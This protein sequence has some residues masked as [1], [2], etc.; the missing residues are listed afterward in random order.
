MELRDG[1]NTRLVWPEIELHVGTDPNGRNV[2]VLTGPEPD[3]AW[4][5]FSRAVGDLA[6]ELGVSKAVFFGAYPFATPHTR[7]SR[8]SSSSP[9][10]ELVTS[11]ALLRNSVDVPAGIAAALEHALHAKGIPVLGMWA[12]V[13]H[14]LGNMTY[15]AASVAL[16]EGLTQ[17]TGVAVDRRALDRETALQ[18]ARI[19]QLIGGNDEH[20]AMVRQLEELYDSSEQ[21]TLALGDGLGPSLT[22]G[23][24][25][26]A[27]ELGEEFE[28]FL[29]EQG[30]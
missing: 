9:S 13:P 6:A 23:S 8:L 2:L 4:R 11:L 17:W 27:D 22:S 30:E 18:R 12:Q 20:L 26:T 25:P 28:R 24:L 29:R 16:V 1:V 10:A 14:Y 19:D 7:P 5:T 3:S 21:Q 15:P